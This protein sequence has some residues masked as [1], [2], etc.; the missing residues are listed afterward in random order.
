MSSVGMHIEMAETQQ[1]CIQTSLKLFCNIVHA[2]FMLSHK[3][4]VELFSCLWCRNG[5]SGDFELTILRVG[6]GGGQVDG[7]SI[8]WRPL[9]AIIH[10]FFTLI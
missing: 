3:W 7:S 9:F 8:L 5:D 6:F 1:G 2:T 4:E 10:N